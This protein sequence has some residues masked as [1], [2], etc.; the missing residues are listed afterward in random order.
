MPTLWLG[1]GVPEK[2]APMR[3]WTSQELDTIGETD[4]LRIATARRD[5]TLR[6]P[7]IIWV[8][9][10]GDDVYV[11]SVN[12][13]ESAWFRGAQTRHEGHVSVGGVERDVAFEELGRDLDDELDAAYRDKYSH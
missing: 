1:P 11:R 3:A 9:R 10:D 6:R 4:E 8:V 12:G 13:R 5:G 2:G 7:V